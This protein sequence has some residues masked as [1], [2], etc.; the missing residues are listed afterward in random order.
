[1]LLVSQFW[2]TICRL[3]AHKLRGNSNN[4]YP[5]NFPPTS[6]VDALMPEKLSSSHATPATMPDKLK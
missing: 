5:P 4:V 3:T 2:F 1:M 6:R